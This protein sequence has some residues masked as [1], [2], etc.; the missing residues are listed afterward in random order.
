MTQDW[1]G[2]LFFDKDGNLKNDEDDAMDKARQRQFSS[3]SEA[4]RYAAQIRWRN[5]QAAA[6][7]EADDAAAMEE[8]RGLAVTATTAFRRLQ[9]DA[10]SQSSRSVPMERADWNGGVL[11]GLNGRHTV[12]NKQLAVA[13]AAKQ[14]LGLKVEA[15]AQRRA[16]QRGMADERQIAQMK[17]RE[18]KQTAKVGAA[19][20]TWQKHQREF[21]VDHP[22]SQ[23]LKEQWRAEGSKL[24]E[25]VKQR[26]AVM[27]N[28]R[29]LLREERLRIINELAPTGRKPWLTRGTDT[30]P[31]KRRE[32]AT[33]IMDATVAEFVPASLVKRLPAVR[34]TFGAGKGR[35]GTYNDNT[36]KI[37]HML[38]KPDQSA[39]LRS[40]FAHEYVHHIQN[41]SKAFRALD[42]A[43]ILRRTRMTSAD[44]RPDTTR[45]VFWDRAPTRAVK[46]HYGN[47]WPDD[48][49]GTTYFMGDKRLK[50]QFSYTEAATTAVQ[51]ML[52]YGSYASLRGDTDLVAHAIGMLV[53][54]A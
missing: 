43:F 19:H 14:D 42:H 37:Q 31:N 11:F 7:A 27:D 35:W 49:S 54:S 24:W 28:N 26:D 33:A 21:G 48:Y 22:K 20:T 9:K 23:E 50:S 15:L 30:V 44:E 10:D 8:I 40:L 32:A 25:L 39:N 5:R 36:I 1:R 51:G 38:H 53:V 41:H 2:V 16:A 52:G 3:R 6:S 18:S 13:E 29:T 12:P 34:V 47:H 17:E 45:A 46:D 4:G